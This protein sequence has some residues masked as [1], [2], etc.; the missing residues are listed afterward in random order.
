MKNEI[1]EDG[2]N[3]RQRRF[4]D[5][6]LIDLNATQAA[7]RAGYSRKTASEQSFSLLRK[8]QIQHAIQLKQKELANQ[9]GVTRQ[10]IIAELAKVAFCDTRKL[11]NDNGTLKPLTE[12]DDDTA[13]ALAMVE[14]SEFSPGDGAGQALAITRK[15]K[16]WDKLSALEKLIKHLGL[17][18]EPKP[19]SGAATENANEGFAELRAAFDK[20]LGKPPAN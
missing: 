11:F 6:Y 3:N 13:G 1:H 4:I 19:E 16:L 15:I 9:A 2:L 5:E 10:R 8:P 12:I 18:A 7:I 20:R 17:N 14:S